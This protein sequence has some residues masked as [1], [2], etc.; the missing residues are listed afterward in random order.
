MVGARNGVAR[1]D[2]E[3]LAGAE[4]NEAADFPGGKEVQSGRGGGT[5]KAE[6]CGG[7]CLPGP[8]G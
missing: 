5:E 1:N 7:I 3:N 4:V 2:G 8:R 6:G